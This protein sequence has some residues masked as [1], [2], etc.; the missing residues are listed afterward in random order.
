MI[1]L[2]HL[3]ASDAY[4]IPITTLFF[5]M[6]TY[7]YEFGIARSTGIPSQMISIGVSLIISDMFDN[8]LYLLT[9]ASLVLTSTRIISKPLYM[10][11]FMALAFI[12]PLL[13]FTDFQKAL[14]FSYVV[15]FIFSFFS[16]SIVYDSLYLQVKNNS[17][18]TYFYLLI[19]GMI[20]IFISFEA[21][22]EYSAPQL[23][24]GNV[25][26]MKS[27]SNVDY[28]V[29]RVYGDNLFAKIYG[30]NDSDL[31]YFKVDDVSKFTFR[32]SIIN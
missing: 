5:Y 25:E 13:I 26:V 19:F 1:L 7:F 8:F 20:S 9:L 17:I 12:S 32:R 29:V 14:I 15:S 22:G 18:G 16:F 11:L 31:I 21:L 30:V 4:V 3:K 27:S 2:R 10:K 28:I 23:L 24:K 6:A